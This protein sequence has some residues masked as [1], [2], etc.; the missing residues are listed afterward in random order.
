M[1][2]NNGMHVSLSE[3][4]DLLRGQ[5]NG[6]ATGMDRLSGESLKFA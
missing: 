1:C 2:F 4:L 5:S 3:V 6:K